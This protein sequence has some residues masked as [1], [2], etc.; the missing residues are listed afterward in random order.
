VKEKCDRIQVADE[1]QLFECLQE[2]LSSIN[3]KELNDIFQVW[4][5]RAQEVSEG[6][7]NYVK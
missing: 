3:Q 7:G 2:P 4:G 6:N 1:D 5:A